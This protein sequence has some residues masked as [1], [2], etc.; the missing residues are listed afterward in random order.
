MTAPMP[1]ELIDIAC[2]IVR[3][4]R[5]GVPRGGSHTHAGTTV[6]IKP[7]VTHV[8]RECTDLERR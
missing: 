2:G 5:C 3:C 8:R 7:D 4:P 6:R 1:Q